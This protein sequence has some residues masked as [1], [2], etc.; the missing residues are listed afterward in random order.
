MEQKLKFGII[1]GGAG[2]FIADLHRR[3]AL[4]DGLST[5]SAGCFSRDY[6]KTLSAG[7]EWGITD[8]DRLYGTYEE[9]AQAEGRRED[10]IDFVIIAAPNDTHYPCA[11]SFLKNGIHVVCDK[12]LTHTSEQAKELKRLA[13]EQDLLFAVTYVYSAYP[14]VRRMRALVQEG[15]L[16]KLLTVDVRYVHGYLMSQKKN[17]HN[18]AWRFDKSRSG[19]AYC[20]A[21]IGTHAEQI[22]SYITGERLDSLCARLEALSTL[23][24]LD[25][26]MHALLRYENGMSG[27]MWCSLIALGHACDLSLGIYGEEAGV[28]WNRQDAEHFTLCYPDG[29]RSVYSAQNKPDRD[30]RD[31]SHCRYPAGH[32]ESVCESFANIYYDF[33]QALLAKKAGRPYPCRYPDIHDGIRGVQFI[34]ACVKSSALQAWVRV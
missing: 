17:P 15:V 13:E 7:K 16:G 1:G 29:S 31:I 27:M 19:I 32:P 22:I 6:Q 14:A 11:R 9:M 23:T 12:P 10:G 24:E 18:D 21:D 4:F 2:S 30:S 8:T 28:E 33:Q 25:T 34:E 26:N 20:T 5:L 3:G